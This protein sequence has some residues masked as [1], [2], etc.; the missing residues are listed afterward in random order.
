[1]TYTI[2]ELRADGSGYMVVT[3]DDGSTFGQMFQDMPVDN[4]AAMVE[5]LSTLAE[6]RAVASLP[7]PA[8]TPHRDAIKYVSVT[9]PINPNRPRGV[10]S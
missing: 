8:K 1:M 10:V 5:A 4:P 6:E 7:R 2:R 9:V 3:R